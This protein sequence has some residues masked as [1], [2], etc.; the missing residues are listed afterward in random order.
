LSVSFRIRRQYFNEIKAGTK[1]KEFRAYSVYWC[2][3]FLKEPEKRPK[4][5]VFVC[6]KDIHRRKILDIKVGTPENELG[7]PISLQGKKDLQLDL[8]D[9]CFIVELGEEVE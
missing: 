4:I 6:G 9:Y 7:R 3:R 5:A 1:T 2:K 8:W